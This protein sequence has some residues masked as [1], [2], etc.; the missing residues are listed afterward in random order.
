LRNSPLLS[1]LAAARRFVREHGAAHLLRVLLYRRVGKHAL[2]L[3][4]NRAAAMLLSAH[5]RFEQPPL[6]MAGTLDWHYPYR[7][8]PH[9]LARALAAQ[10]VPIV[11]VSPMQGY[12]RGFTVTHAASAVLVTPHLTEAIAVSPGSWVYVA[13]TDALALP[14][15]VELASRF[16]TRILYDYLDRV[17]PWISN[18]PIDAAF[19]A[20]HSRVLRDESMAAVIASAD[21]LHRD[22]ARYRRGNHALV[23]NGV[24]VEHF[25][26]SRDEAM[27]RPQLR[28]LVQRGV[29]IVGFFGTLA[30]WI[31]IRLVVEV[32]R[33][34]PGYQFAIIGPMLAKAPL[35]IDGVP[36]NLHLVGPV[37]YEDLPSQAIFC[38][39]LML[40]FRIDEITNATSPLKLFEYMA[41]RVPIVSTPIPEAR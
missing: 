39:V 18:G 36:A 40:P 10:G 9:H 2:V 4:R 27:L 35:A 25:S 32:A 22:V 24:D 28:R 7:Q 8:R 21:A 14:R 41:L 34:R 1:R 3:C 31:D 19:E 33:L 13:S 20:A 23:T 37:P 6:I 29:P 17:D 11:Y 26:A 15:V 16:G 38:D 30:P 12:D 5:G